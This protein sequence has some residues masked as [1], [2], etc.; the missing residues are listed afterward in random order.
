MV[1]CPDGS[2]IIR[3]SATGSVSGPEALGVSLA[4]ELL[5]RGARTILNEVYRAAER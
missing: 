4:E 1:G 2:E 3:G 5:D